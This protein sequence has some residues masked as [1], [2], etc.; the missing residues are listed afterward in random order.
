MQKKIVI[1]G[2]SGA[3]GKA[4]VDLYSKIDTVEHVFSFSKTQIDF[5][6]SKVKSFSIDIEDEISVKKAAEVIG[7]QKIDIVIVATGILHNKDFGPEKSIKDLDPDNFLKVLKINT[8]GP[9]IIGKHFLP[10]L[11]KDQKSVFAFLSARVGSI[12]ENKL[13]GWYS[14]RASK[15]ALNQVVKNFSIEVFRTNPNAVI[16]GLQPGTVESNLSQ[17][18]KK[19]VA[20]EKLFTPE[21]SAEMLAKVILNSTQKNSGDLLSWDGEIINP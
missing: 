9:A 8:I 17:P 20:R 14:Y 5:S 18:F 3:I 2:A 13:G 4:F 21:Y 6:S 10:L 16:L 7:T 15:T 1:I 12:S 11:T 19:N